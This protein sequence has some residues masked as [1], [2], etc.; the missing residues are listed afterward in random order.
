MASTSYCKYVKISKVTSVCVVV[1]LLSFFYFPNVHFTDLY[2][3]FYI[4]RV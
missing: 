2:S 3:I 1:S 4:C